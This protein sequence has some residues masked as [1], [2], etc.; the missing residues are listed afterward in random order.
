MEYPAESA[1]LAGRHLFEP[2]VVNRPPLAGRST[3]KVVAFNARGGRHLE[4]IVDCLRRR[5]L[6]GADVILLCEAAWRHRRSGGRE[7]VA[8]LAEALK[9]SFAFVAQFAVPRAAGPPTAFLGSAIVSSRP[10]S[11]VDA[12]PLSH[13][14]RARLVRGLI[15]TAAAL[16][17]TATFNGKTIALGVAHLNSRGSPGGREQQMREFLTRFP[18]E[19][20]AV[21]GG[22]FNTTTVDLRNREAIMR[23]VRKLVLEPSR[24][25]A[26]QRWEP[27]FERLAQA[28]FAVK[29]ANAPRRQTFTLSGIIPPPIRLKLD[30]IAARGLD[31]V[32]G[33]A[34]VIP[35]RKSILSSRLSDHDFVVCDLRA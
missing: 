4:G 22:D 33:S 24:L 9:M 23:A 14:V 27:L 34:A 12:V 20:P 26:P 11:E 13:K 5:P 21:V 30:W 32:P 18:R 17:A 10:L 3:L 19:G 29:G 16:T 2:I 31:P 7:F 8:E 25:W 1:P 35:A 15:G 28:G 6:Q